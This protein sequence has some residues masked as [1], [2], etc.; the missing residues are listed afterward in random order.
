MSFRYFWRTRLVALGGALIAPLAAVDAWHKGETI[1]LWAI[2]MLS[3]HSICAV[4]FAWILRGEILTGPAGLGFRFRGR[5]SWIEWGRIET[6]ERRRLGG[7][8]RVRGAGREIRFNDQIRGYPELC[9]ELAARAPQWTRQG[10]L[11]V[12]FEIRASAMSWAVLALLVGTGSWMIQLAAASANDPP[13]T[14]AVAAVG[15][16]AMASYGAGRVVRS[17]WFGRDEIVVRYLIRPAGR[18]GAGQLLRA[19][20]TTVAYRGARVVGLLLEF[21]DGR[22]LIFGP[23]QFNHPVSA[24]LDAVR[25]GYR[26]R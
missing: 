13:W 1:P 23:T 14:R 21:E 3:G 11:H 5:E 22:K 10:G 2:G 18:F 15:G 24:I 9:S 26:F 8:V 19:S 4:W 25:R 20:E 6:I 16:L 7:E 12:P 17:V